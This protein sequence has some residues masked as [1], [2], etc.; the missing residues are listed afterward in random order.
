MSETAAS[1]PA[2]VEMCVAN[3]HPAVIPADYLG[4]DDLRGLGLDEATITRLLRDTPLT[5]DGGRPVLE[6]AW[7][8]DLVDMLKHEGLR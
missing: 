5:G 6:A 7:L 8:P 2:R 3:V 4:E 1:N